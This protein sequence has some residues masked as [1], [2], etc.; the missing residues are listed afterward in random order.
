VAVERSALPTFGGSGRIT[1]AAREQAPR[2]A[3][4]S[5]TLAPAIASPFTV[6]PQ[7]AVVTTPHFTQVA[8]FDLDGE[9]EVVI[10]FP[11]HAQEIGYSSPAPGPRL[12]LFA[13]GAFKYLVDEIEGVARAAVAHTDTSLR[14]AVAAPTTDPELAVAAST[15]AAKAGPAA[16][17]AV[18]VASTERVV[19]GS[20]GREP[21]VDGAAVFADLRYA[22]VL[23]PLAQGKLEMPEPTRLAVAR[24]A[25]SM[26]QSGNRSETSTLLTALVKGE[27]AEAGDP[28]S[29]APMLAGL[30]V[31]MS[32]I[33][34]AALEEGLQ[35][36]L[37]GL[38]KL[39]KQGV[40]NATG[41]E[42]TK[43]V[44]LTV[45]AGAAGWGIA[46][47]QTRRPVPEAVLA[48]ADED[49]SWTWLSHLAEPEQGEK[50]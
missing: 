28:A 25:G 45:A 4:F 44:V 23:P 32:Q 18:A 39:G 26:A 24:E 17:A 48:G 10:F 2:F 12:G 1:S 9:Q 34:P 40:Q 13:G 31:E 6:G 7:K 35:H 19:H 16:P 42:W 37:D 47:W 5:D 30:V 27:E 14:A 21:I 15:V 50:P 46:R 3:A 36:F 11:G 8:I 49:S 20:E 38:S 29:P 22:S 43:W 41:T 33:S